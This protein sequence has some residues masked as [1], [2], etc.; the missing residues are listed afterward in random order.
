MVTEVGIR[1][2]W[3]VRDLGGDDDLDIFV[4]EKLHHDKYLRFMYFIVCVIL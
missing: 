2:Y 4:R 3:L 1:M